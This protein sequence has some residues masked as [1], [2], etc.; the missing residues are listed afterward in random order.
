MLTFHLAPATDFKP[1]APVYVPCTYS[2]DGFVHTSNTLAALA[3]AGN[4]YY[5]GDSR[6]Y[7]VLTIDL[8]RLDVPWRYDAAG[9]LFPHIYGPVH[10]QA[11]VARHHA[12]RAPDGAF[13]P[14]LGAPVSDDCA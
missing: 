9:E 6:P 12:V 3:G 8:E 13:R 2:V 10:R 14:Q 7:L 11:I 1:C 5:S 4:R